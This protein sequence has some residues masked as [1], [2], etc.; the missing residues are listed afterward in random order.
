MEL[1]KQ[2][3]FEDEW[4]IA[5]VRSTGPGGQN[6]NKVSSKVEL[7]FNVAQTA[8]LTDGEKETV[9]ARLGNR[10]NLVGELVLSCQTERS[11]LRNK[12]KVI[13][14][15][16]NLLGAALT[17]VKKRKATKPTHGSVVERLGQKRMRA[18]RKSNRRK[19]SDHD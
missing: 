13:D 7:R 10:I 6:V 15:F 2:R 14:K 3:G 9:R 1:L 8:L 16:F 5:A 11:Q 12:E 17:P 18:E 4:V 19:I